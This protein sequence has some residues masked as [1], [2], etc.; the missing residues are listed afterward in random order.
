MLG[1]QLVYLRILKDLDVIVRDSRNIPSCPS[2]WEVPQNSWLETTSAT[3]TTSPNCIPAVLSKMV[4]KQANSHSDAFWGGTQIEW[5]IQK[6][7]TR[8]R[9]HPF[10]E[11][12]QPHFTSPHHLRLDVYRHY[13]N[14]R[15]VL[16]PQIRS[17]TTNPGLHHQPV[18][19]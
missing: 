3:S 4:R 9:C 1:V 19:S 16:G 5:G 15:K 10:R 17:D 13:L 14:T 7:T 12:R 18:N 11:A 8:G 6:E 2:Y